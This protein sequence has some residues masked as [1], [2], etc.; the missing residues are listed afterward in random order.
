[1]PFGLTMTCQN[2][3][4]LTGMMQKWWRLTFEVRLSEAPFTVRRM[5]EKMRENLKK[6]SEGEK[7]DGKIEQVGEKKNS[8]S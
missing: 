3:E 5:F 6:E 2:T 1:M 7:R 4:C 8:V